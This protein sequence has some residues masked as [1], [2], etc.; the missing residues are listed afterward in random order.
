MSICL[1]ITAREKHTHHMGVLRTLGATEDSR[2]CLAIKERWVISCS[3][4]SAPVLSKGSR[5]G[6]LHQPEESKGLESRV[7]NAGF[8][9]LRTTKN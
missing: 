5:Y 3:T 2:A 6:A 4:C 7:E 9:E 1:D 8:G